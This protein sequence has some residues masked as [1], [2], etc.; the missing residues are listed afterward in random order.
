MESLSVCFQTNVIRIK[1]YES[2]KK[3]I[4]EVCENKSERKPLKC[5]RI[6]PLLV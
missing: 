6:G 5:E 4:G 1:R 2:I 3:I